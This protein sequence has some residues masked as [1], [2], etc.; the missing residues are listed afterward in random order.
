MP[1][2]N[3][4]GSGPL[5]IPLQAPAGSSVEWSVFTTAFRKILDV[6]QS[7][8]GNNAVLSW[9]LRDS[10]GRTVADGLYFI[11]VQVTG[12]VKATK[13]LKVLVFR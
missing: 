11:R 5:L 12:T 3:P 9:D 8:P 2:P 13:V 6:T 10:R 4:T 7:I 1:Y